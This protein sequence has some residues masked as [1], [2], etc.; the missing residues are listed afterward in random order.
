MSGRWVVRDVQSVRPFARSVLSGF[1]LRGRMAVIVSC[2]E[3]FTPDQ[4]FPYC[5]T[6]ENFFLL[7]T[8]K[9][10]PSTWQ[11]VKRF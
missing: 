6:K 10:T 3:N 11:N 9:S 7:M 1:V 2:N 5:A 8:W 4:L